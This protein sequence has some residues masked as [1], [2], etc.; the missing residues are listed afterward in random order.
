MFL[1]NINRLVWVK[2]IVCVY[3]EVVAEISKQ[4]L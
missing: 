4:N 3:F 2:E 1:S